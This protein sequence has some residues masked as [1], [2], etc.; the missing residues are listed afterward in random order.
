LGNQAG[1]VFQRDGNLIDKAVCF[2]LGSKPDQETT[3]SFL[4][5]F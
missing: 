4:P 5:D 2:S 3:C 1:F